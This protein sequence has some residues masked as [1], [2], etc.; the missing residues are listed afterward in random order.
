[1]RQGWNVFVGYALVPRKAWWLF[2]SDPLQRLRSSRFPVKLVHRCQCTQV[3][4]VRFSWSSGTP[5][6]QWPP[7]AGPTEAAR[8]RHAAHAAVRSLFPQSLTVSSSLLFDR[9][10]PHRR[11]QDAILVAVLVVLDID[12]VV[13]CG[14]RWWSLH[15]YSCSLIGP[16]RWNMCT[17]AKQEVV[18]SWWRLSKSWLNLFFLGSYGRIWDCWCFCSV[19]MN[20]EN[21]QEEGIHGDL[22][23]KSSFVL[24]QTDLSRFYSQRGKM[25][26][27][28]TDCQSNLLFWFDNARSPSTDVAI[29]NSLGCQQYD[30]ASDGEPSSKKKKYADWTRNL[31]D[32]TTLNYLRHCSVTNPFP[33][34]QETVSFGSLPLFHFNL[35][36]WNSPVV[37]IKEP[38]CLDV[39]HGYMIHHRTGRL[40]FARTTQVN[41]LLWNTLY[42]LITIQSSYSSC[43]EN[44]ERLYLFWFGARLSISLTML[45]ASNRQLKPDENP[46]KTFPKMCYRFL[47]LQLSC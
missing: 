20:D 10:K 39:F 12:G 8:C 32:V 38:W 1:M 35:D 41:I 27:H 11:Y 37:E 25:E 16:V 21:L 14:N 2:P 15:G 47:L 43:W 3:D 42:S 5:S 28:V 29:I 19:D 30:V 36:P 18:K 46:S 24:P 4:L 13:Q 23:K 44:D 40:I 34:K 7:T 31:K 6:T 17:M 26:F 9:N 22:K 33:M 45:Y